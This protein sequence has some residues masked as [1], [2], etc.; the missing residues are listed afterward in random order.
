MLAHPGR[1]ADLLCCQLDPREGG[2][3]SAGGDAWASIDRAHPAPCGRAGGA[4]P[5]RGPLQPRSLKQLIEKFGERGIGLRSLTEAIDTT[6]AG[7]KLVFH[8][9]AAQSAQ[10]S[11]RDFDVAT[12][13]FLQCPQAAFAG[14]A[15]LY[16]AAAELGLPIGPRRPP[17]AR[18]L[19]G[20][21]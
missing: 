5:E 3:T 14:G 13:C 15:R 16:L 17:R 19:G 11:G 10:Y 7:G 6:T 1:A 2:P 21:L 8:I 4:D 20:T 9:F 18:M 12:G